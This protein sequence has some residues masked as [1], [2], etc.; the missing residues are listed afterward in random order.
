M[1]WEPLIPILTGIASSIA[2][3]VFG[4]DEERSTAQRPYT[5]REMMPPGLGTQWDRTL[6]AMPQKYNVGFGG[7]S[8]PML[9]KNALNAATSL[10]GP[11][12]GAPAPTP[13]SFTSG[14]IG[15][16]PGIMQGLTNLWDNTNVMPT[17]TSAYTPPANYTGMI[18]QYTQPTISNPY[19]RQFM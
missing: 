19:F 15:A 8:Y 13:N 6:A 3:S 5:A 17:T 2:G 18:N 9:N 14:M 12:M 4:G 1:F 16:M 10:Y 11:S 7:K